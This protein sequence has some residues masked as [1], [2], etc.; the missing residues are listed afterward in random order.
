MAANP[1]SIPITELFWSLLDKADRKFSLLRDLPSFS[2]NRND[3]DFHKAFKIYTQLWK[4]QQEHRQKLIDAGLKRWEVGELASRIAQLY[5]GQYQ[6]TS[7]SSFLSEAFIFYEAILSREYFRDASSS[8]PDPALA[9][10]QLRFL[11]RFLIVCLLLGRRDMV[12]RLA[13][14][15]RV[16]LDE[17][18]KNFQETDFKEWKHVVQEIFR[19]MKVDTPF[20]NMRPLRYS[21][22]YDS[23]PNSLSVSSH[24]NRRLVLRDSILSTYHHNEVKFTELTIDTYRM[25]QCLEWEPC[26]SFS[27]KGG[28]NSGHNES[29]PNRVN[30]LQDIRD[31]SLPPNPRKVILYR[32]SITHYL[33]VL[34]ELE[35]IH[36]AEKG[37]TIAMLLSPI[38][39]LIGTDFAPDSVRHQHG[40]YFTLFL[41]APL[42]A[43]CLL[44]NISG[45]NLDKDTYNKAEKLLSSSLSEWESTLLTSASLHP[46]WVEALGDPFL[47]RLLLRYIFCR[48]VYALYAKT[49]RREE[50]LPACLPHLP[51]S[52]LPEETISQTA[53][54]RLANMFNVKDYFAFSDG[55][56][57]SELDENESTTDEC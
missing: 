20:I 18:K 21:F 56:A 28:A 3:L 1:S 9:N 49:F 25:V 53:V 23:N 24:A 40:S 33:M 45:M 38:S 30:L 48:T 37:E 51:D 14:Q 15:L 10:K 4:M 17:C 46:V 41:T 29:G 6:R 36:G 42:Q 54:L 47:R 35:I 8:S 19:F 43:F 27:L 26:G 2:R 44:V 16:V 7:D 39:Q 13:N 50:F 52:V 34:V 32:P 12:S 31:P 55:I 5:Y 57:A 11:A 22:V